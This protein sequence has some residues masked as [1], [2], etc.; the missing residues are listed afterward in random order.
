MPKGGRY[1]ESAGAAKGFPT[2]AGVRETGKDSGR[3]DGKGRDM[4]NRVQAGCTTAV[5]NPETFLSGGLKTG[6]IAF[7]FRAESINSL[8]A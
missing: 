2:P 4:G 8:E 3:S 5:A 1:P 6:I 7:T